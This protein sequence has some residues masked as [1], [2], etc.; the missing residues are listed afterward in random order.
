MTFLFE[1]VCLFAGK[2]KIKPSLVFLSV[3]GVFMAVYLCLN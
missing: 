2:P 3:T 1:V